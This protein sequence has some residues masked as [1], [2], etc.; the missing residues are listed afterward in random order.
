MIAGI[1]KE[2]RPLGLKRERGNDALAPEKRKTSSRGKGPGRKKRTLRERRRRQTDF[3]EVN[4]VE[5]NYRRA[6]AARGGDRG[7]QGKAGRGIGRSCGR[8]KKD[9]GRGPEGAM[10]KNGEGWGFSNGSLTCIVD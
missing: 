6:Q 3:V 5:K 9:G 7:G 8:P 10:G 4:H 1:S 2:N